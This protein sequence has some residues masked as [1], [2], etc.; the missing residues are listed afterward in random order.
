MNRPVGIFDSGLGGLTVFRAIAELLPAERLI[1]LGDTARVPYGTKS[2][3]T[4]VR[5]SQENTEFLLDQDVKAV[6]VA[7]NTA[8]AYAVPRLQ[9][10]FKPPVLGVLEPGARQAI[11]HSAQKRIGVIGTAGTVT[12]GA[13]ERVLQNIDSQVQVVS[14]ACPLFVPLVEE[15]WLDAEETRSIARHYLEPLLRAEVDTLILG[16]THYPMLRPVIADIMGPDVVLIDSAQAV[17]EALQ[18]LLK[19]QH[20]LRAESRRGGPTDHQFFVTDSP[21][22]FR[23]V[24]EI[25]LGH[26]LENVQKVNS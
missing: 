12:S 3:Q 22:R 10:H 9:R 25:F 2:A 1:Y 8:S 17:A 23:R 4:V 13:Y 26:P 16:C 21:E 20:L 18:E 19:S 7:C 5:Y 11:A 24:G 14:E 15:G 6:V